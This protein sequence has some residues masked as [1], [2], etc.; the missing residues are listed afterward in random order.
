MIACV[1][2]F[3]LGMCGFFRGTHYKSRDGNGASSMCARATAVQHVFTMVLRVAEKC[4]LDDAAMMD[5]THRK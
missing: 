3:S 1:L 4:C 5:K 2:D